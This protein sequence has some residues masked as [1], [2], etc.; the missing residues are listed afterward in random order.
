MKRTVDIELKLT[1][2]EIAQEFCS[3]DSK[4]QALFFNNVA[5]IVTEEW[6]GTFCFQLQAVTDEEVLTPAGRYVMSQIG[7]YSEKPI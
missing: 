1:P 4:D 7:D 3:M 2:R 6:D 5:Q